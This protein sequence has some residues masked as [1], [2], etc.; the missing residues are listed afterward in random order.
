[1]QNDDKFI[2]KGIIWETLEVF[3]VILILISMTGLLGYLLF[4]WPNTVVCGIITIVALVLLL[5]S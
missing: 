3:T 2:Y 1:M 5:D 4:L